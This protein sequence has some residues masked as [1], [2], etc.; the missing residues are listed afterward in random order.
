M[1][2]SKGVPLISSEN[3]MDK[4]FVKIQ[5]CAW[6]GGVGNWFTRDC[7]S[8]INSKGGYFFWLLFELEGEI[9]SG[10]IIGLSVL[11]SHLSISFTWKSYNKELILKS[12]LNLM[13]S[14]IKISIFF[15]KKK[16]IS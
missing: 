4:V 13:Q 7:K 15:K 8:L 12:C 6:G 14:S 10:N 3:V 1:K 16:S 2:I 9:F 5:V 11:L